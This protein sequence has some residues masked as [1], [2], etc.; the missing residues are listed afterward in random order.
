MK[1]KA[2]STN[3]PEAFDDL[4]GKPR[5]TRESRETRMVTQQSRQPVEKERKHLHFR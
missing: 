1:I 4:G 2:W 5:K 3:K